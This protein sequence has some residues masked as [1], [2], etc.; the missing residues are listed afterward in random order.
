MRPPII[1]VYDANILYP[2]ALRDLFI[3]LAHA[4]LACLRQF[5]SLV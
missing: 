3:R 2:A 4:G 5:V 1:V